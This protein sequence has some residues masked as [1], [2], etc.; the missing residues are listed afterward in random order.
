MKSGVFQNI[1]QT[2]LLTGL[3]LW[4]SS[5]AQVRA[6]SG[7][8]A[9]KT[10]GS[11]NIQTKKASAPSNEM[12]LPRSKPYAQ[13]SEIHEHAIENLVLQIRTVKLSV[14]YVRGVLQSP[15]QSTAQLDA[16]FRIMGMSCTAAESSSKNLANAKACF[17]RYQRDQFT[18]MNA[19]QKATAA[20]E[21]EV[22]RLRGRGRNGPQAPGEVQSAFTVAF[23]G[24]LDEHPIDIPSLEEVDA[25]FQK[26]KPQDRKISQNQ[27][28]EWARSPVRKPDPK[29]FVQFKTILRDPDDPRSGTV[30]V[31]VTNPDGTLKLDEQAYKSAL[32]S[33]DGEKGTGEEDRRKDQAEREKDFI[34]NAQKNQNAA[35]IRLE[36]PS[37]LGTEEK[38]IFNTARYEIVSAAANQ[39]SKDGR[40]A[41][42]KKLTDGDFSTATGK[43]KI[44]HSRMKGQAIYLRLP[45]SDIL[46]DM[47]EISKPLK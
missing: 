25:S 3:C 7:A 27:V 44:D 9:P 22:G 26:M 30:T 23:D 8:V 4:M 47:E 15:S 32:K 19:L 36:R 18:R 34:A 38:Q 10:F 31:A 33:F 28:S 2:A 41:P 43:E 20:S 21:T 1:S 12:A 39:F 5:P 16:V 6:D 17:G 40:M 37:N 35:S 42:M 11:Q 14:S 24:P 46:K 45:A 13:I 29:D